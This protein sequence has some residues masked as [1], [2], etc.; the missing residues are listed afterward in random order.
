MEIIKAENLI[1][2]YKKYDSE[3]N[4]EI[5][6]R[7][8]NGI[9]LSIEK[10]SFTAILGHNGSGKSTFAKHIN[11]LLQPTEGKVY[12]EGMDTGDN[13]VIW[14]IRQKAGMVFQNPDNQIIATI[15][16]EDIA[17]GAENLGIEPSEIRKRVD[18][19]LR[20]VNMEEFKKSTPSKLSGG[21]KQRIAIA[22]VLAMLPD[23]I[24]LDE[25]TAMLDPMGRIEVLNTL[26]R[27]N[28]ER[29]IT[30]VLITHFME[31]AAKA[32]RVIVVNDGK[33]VMDGTPKEV[34]SDIH[35]MRALGLDV[36]AVTELAYEL[37]EMGIQVPLDIITL[38]EMAE[39]LCQ[40]K[41]RI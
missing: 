22:G 32:D 30:I 14:D 35:K 23:I 9:S 34:F 10:G 38:D 26:L 16:E 20:A 4:K 8:I 19:S 18:E 33:S 7:A 1:F 25:P 11:V 27:L 3:A 36:P 17:F 29:G 24:V 37:N 13:S 21:Q 12:V 15:V 28:R 5:T 41:S 31:E 2:D 39:A 6:I 40:L